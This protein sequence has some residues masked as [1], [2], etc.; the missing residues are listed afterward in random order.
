MA[1]SPN[2]R[3]L[4][5]NS[6]IDIDVISLK[7]IS[8]EFNGIPVLSGISFELQSGRSISIIGPSGCGKTTL[9]YIIAGLLRPSGGSVLINN[10]E[11]KEAGYK[12][13]FILQD[14]GLLPWKT[15]FKNVSLAMRIKK[16]PGDEIRGRVEKILKEMQIYSLKDRY[17]SNLSGGEKQR[18]A[19]ARALATEPEILL[20]DEPFSSLDTLTR[21]KLQNSVV[22][23]QSGR[24]LSMLLVSHSI[25][26][27][28]FLG[29][30]IIIMS[31]SPGRI[32]KII[33]N[34]RSGGKRF[35]DSEH[36]FEQCRRVRG[37]IES[38]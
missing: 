25:E 17:P 24:S 37:I 6:S 27:A 9:L 2:M 32:E 21:E 20:M 1:D 29:D 5:G 11:V 31:K 33:D 3:K 30:R 38:L 35:R 13:S 36:Y 28:V 19:I 7:N 18:V 15:V 8:R 14:Y 10:M 16:M 23:I 34:E 12:T 26:E 4:S 22:D